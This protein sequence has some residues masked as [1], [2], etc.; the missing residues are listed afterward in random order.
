MDKI[1]INNLENAN[2]DFTIEII[3]FYKEVDK[4][5]INNL[6]NDNETKD[7]LNISSK[8]DLNIL[9]K[10]KNNWVMKD[11]RKI[12][13]E[14]DVVKKKKVKEITSNF[15]N[16]TKP[17]QTIN[18][19]KDTNNKLISEIESIDNFKK[20]IENENIYNKLKNLASLNSTP[21][22][23]ITK[24]NISNIKGGSNIKKENTFIVKIVDLKDK[25]SNSESSSDFL[26][27]FSNNFK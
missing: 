16:I 6:I 20:N 4:K 11:K 7:I 12:L 3:D 25:I 19:L 14:I 26:E 5:I 13:K 9:K 24:K 17:N 18:I 22:T 1:K 2:Q 27:I 23:K 15:N 8:N 10:D 21:Q